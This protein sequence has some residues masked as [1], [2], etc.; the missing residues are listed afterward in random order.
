MLLDIRC[1]AG[2]VQISEDRILSVVRGHKVFW[3]VPVSTVLRIEQQPG[4]LFIHTTFI[5]RIGNY[6]VDVS[7][8]DFVKLQ[9]VIAPLLS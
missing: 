4:A 1:T 3:S 7:R 2:K 6:T 8:Q 9:Q 5:S